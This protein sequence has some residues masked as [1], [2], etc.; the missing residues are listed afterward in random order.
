MPVI[1]QTLQNYHVLSAL[2]VCVHLLN[3]NIYYAVIEKEN[4]SGTHQNLVIYRRRPGSGT[5]ELVKKFEGAGGY[6]KA[7]VDIG[8]ALIL[9]D[10]SLE[11]AFTGVPLDGS[12]TSGT[13]FSAITANVPGV[14]EPWA[15]PKQSVAAIP[16][17][18]VELNHPGDFDTYRGAD[19]SHMTSNERVN[20]QWVHFFS[21]C[22]KGPRG[23]GVHVF[24]QVGAKGQAEYVWYTNGPL[25]QGRGDMDLDAD[26]TLQVNGSWSDSDEDAVSCPVPGYVPFGNLITI[27]NSVG[28]G[29]SGP[30]VDTSALEAR[31]AAV[32]K[33]AQKALDRANYVKSASV[34][35]LWA[36]VGALKERPVGISRDE[37]WK[38]A[39]DRQYAELTTEGS[40]VREALDAIIRAAVQDALAGAQNVAA[41]VQKALDAQWQ[42]WVSYTDRRLLNLLWDRA[43]K[44]LRYKE[45]T[46]KPADQLPINDP[47]NLEV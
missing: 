42:A 16:D 12:D 6:A 29:G 39:A 14:D 36:E 13:Q 44:L 18:I 5:F 9:Q 8:G 24:K 4:N 40:G 26:G 43:V 3:G 35:P 19:K 37:A 32:E 34:D 25:L 27:L 11:V 17:E 20:G 30:V 22:G 1:P 15:M 38:L 33:L 2:P 45:R 10:G 41:E 47:K 46:G 7:Q 28:G 21:Q 31:L 23:F